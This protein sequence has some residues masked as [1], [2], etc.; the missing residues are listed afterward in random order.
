MPELRK[1]PVV[2]RW[3]IMAPERADRPQAWLRRRGGTGLDEDDDPAHCPFC[4]GNE[5]MTPPEIY[6]HREGARWDVRVVPNR[7][8]ALRTEIPPGRRGHGPFDQINGTGAHEVVIETP[9]HGRSLAQ[10]PPDALVEVLA[11]WQVRMRD[12][13]RDERLRC[14]LVFKNAGAAAGATLSHAHSQL[15][16]LPT[17]PTELQ[18]ELEAARAH[19]DRKQRCVYC[20]LLDHELDAKERVVHRGERFASLAPWASRS[21]FETWIFPR[22]HQSRFE[23]LEEAD[24]AAF[25]AELGLLLRKIDVALEQPALN[26]FLHTAPLRDPELPWYHWHL[27]VKPVVTSVGGF[28]WGSGWFINPTPPEEAASFLR[29]TEV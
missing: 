18:Q 15:I 1:D 28:E 8:P 29:Q 23:H 9:E 5:S 27:T 7:Y 25:A 12:L 11:A 19:W 26:L 14:A 16:A 24:L 22:A 4:P 10:L 13:A 3:V 17:V 21:P 2:D 20:D 6:A